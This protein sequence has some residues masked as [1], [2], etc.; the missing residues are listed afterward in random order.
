MQITKN[1]LSQLYEKLDE[2]CFTING[3]RVNTPDKGDVMFEILFLDNRE[4][5]FS[6]L[7][8]QHASSYKISYCPGRIH[9]KVSSNI[10]S[11]ERCLEEMDSWF[12]NIKNEIIASHPL[13]N[14]FEMLKTR[15]NEFIEERYTKADE[16][17]STAEIN[18]LKS[19]LDNLTCQFQELQEK[20]A[21]TEKELEIVKQTVDE[22]KKN[23]DFFPKKTW[24][25]SAG[26]KLLQLVAKTHGS[27]TGQKLLTESARSLVGIPP[28]ED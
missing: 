20:N 18:E 24:F 6:F 23:V 16:T 19:M 17:F 13:Y 11:F 5:V 3:F 26:N 4:Y 9:Y 22:L 27:G 21:M 1:C 25:R 10:E 8:P 7:N 14:E 2:S 28:D 12:A 15:L